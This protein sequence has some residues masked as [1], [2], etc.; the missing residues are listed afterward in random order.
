MYVIGYPSWGLSETM[1]VKGISDKLISHVYI[2]QQKQK[3]SKL[4]EYFI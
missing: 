4:G 1:S 2:T 3:E